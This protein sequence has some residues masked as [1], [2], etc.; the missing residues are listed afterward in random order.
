MANKTSV[1]PNDPQSPRWLLDLQQWRIV[2]YTDIPQ[3]ILDGEG[4]GVVSYTWGYIV[5]D[6]K[7]ASDPPQGLLWDVP[8]VKGW[9]LA[10]A[11]RVMETIGTR[12]IWWDW[13]CVP[14]SGEQMRPWDKKLD[15]GKVQGEEIGKQL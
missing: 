8:A 9:T 10:K 13:M 6:G 1:P 15:L 14:Q 5:D 2:P 12:Y 7:P 4:Y 3:R 11:R